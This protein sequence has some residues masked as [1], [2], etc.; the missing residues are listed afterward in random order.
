MAYRSYDFVAQNQCVAWLDVGCGII[1]WL[2]NVIVINRDLGWNQSQSYLKCS[3]WPDYRH[4]DNTPFIYIKYSGSYLAV[5]NMLT[6]VI[7]TP[8]DGDITD[9]GGTRPL[10]RVPVTPRQYF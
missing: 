5:L 4:G 6:Q 7:L 8:D 3:W 10:T 2:E 9:T 1:V